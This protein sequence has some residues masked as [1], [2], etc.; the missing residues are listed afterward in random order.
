MMDVT[1]RSSSIGRAA[2]EVD[3]GDGHV[4]EVAASHNTDRYREVRLW[5]RA[6][7]KVTGPREEV[8]A[9]QVI[10]LVSSRLD[11]RAATHEKKEKQR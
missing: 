9:R 4:L 1:V 8:R 10:T 11:L 7:G 5:W 2:V 6:P 3:L